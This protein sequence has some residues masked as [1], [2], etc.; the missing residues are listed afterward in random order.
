MDSNAA[1]LTTAD[2]KFAGVVIFDGFER[3]VKLGKRVDHL[4]CVNIENPHSSR[5]E[6]ASE[7]WE[8]RMTGNAKRLLIGGGELIELVK[9]LHIPKSDCFIFTNCDQIHLHVVEIKSNYF[10][11]M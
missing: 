11:S 4:S 3:L 10:I 8:S 7:D 5:V 2:Q 9:G 6:A 1:I